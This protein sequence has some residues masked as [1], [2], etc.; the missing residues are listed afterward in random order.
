[1]WKTSSGWLMGVVLLGTV[2]RWETSSMIRYLRVSIIDRFP[3]TNCVCRCRRISKVKNVM[4]SG[5]IMTFR[6]K[7]ALNEDYEQKTSCTALPRGFAPFTRQRRP[8]TLVS[9]NF[10]WPD[11]SQEGIVRPLW[12]LRLSPS[13]L[14]DVVA[15]DP[16]FSSFIVLLHLYTVF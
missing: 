5:V 15:G 14:F 8:N 11:P 6:K 12:K 10:L 3:T 7:R 2:T 13:S 1:M 9:T 4:R 16:Q